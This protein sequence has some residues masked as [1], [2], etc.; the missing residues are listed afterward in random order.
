MRLLY[1]ILLALLLGLT[2]CGI[3]RPGIPDGGDPLPPPPKP[4]E[5]IVI[6]QPNNVA[7]CMTNEEFGRWVQRNL[8]GGGGW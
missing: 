8:P 1:V 3:L 2:G 6:V 4:C 5:K 7:H